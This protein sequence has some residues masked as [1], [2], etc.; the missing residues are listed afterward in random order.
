MCRSLAEVTGELRS[1][2]Q[3]FEM[4]MFKHIT[5]LNRME[6]RYDV[7]PEVASVVRSLYKGEVPRTKDKGPGEEDQAPRTPIPTISPEEL[8]EIKA[9]FIGGFMVLCCL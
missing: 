4:E 6:K 7:A 1:Y 9:E 8:A 5:M 3:K 2:P